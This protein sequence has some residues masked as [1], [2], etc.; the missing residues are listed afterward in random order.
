MSSCIV[1]PSGGRGRWSRGA[2]SLREREGRDPP[3]PCAAGDRVRT[4]LALL[5][6][7]REGVREAEAESARPFARDGAECMS[8]GA[9]VAAD[10]GE[11]VTSGSSLANSR[12]PTPRT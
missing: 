12:G 10:L 8:L 4:S 5:T 1:S 3:R 6:G 7:Y 11:I 9:G 2:L